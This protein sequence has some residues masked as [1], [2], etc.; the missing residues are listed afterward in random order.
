MNLPHAVIPVQVALEGVISWRVLRADGRVKSRGQMRNTITNA[1][2]DAIGGGT[3]VGSL[4]AYL[5][6]G[7]GVAAP[8]TG[9]TTLGSPHAT[10]VNRTST[11]DDT[12]TAA[13]VA[14]Y[15]G[16]WARVRKF[17]ETEATGIWTEVG[18]FSASSGGTM[19]N[20]QLFKDGGG[21]PVSVEVLAD[22]QL[23]VTLN[24]RLYSPAWDDA[25]DDVT[26]SFTLDE[27]IGAVVTPVTYNYTIRPQ[28]VNA[29]SWSP[30]HLGDWT[31]N[32]C[33]ARNSASFV[34]ITSSATGTAESSHSTTSY[35]GGTYY[36]DQEHV[37]EPAN[38]TTDIGMLVFYNLT[39]SASNAQVFQCALSPVIPKTSAKRLRV[40]VRY[41]FARYP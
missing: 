26:G 21:S 27:I 24:V 20:R 31:N 7:T 29:T 22:E 33:A 38:V 30:E 19:F 32:R 41:S 40:T 10:R 16:Q 35:V 4:T 1:A 37:W 14:P 28:R 13:S 5:A 6:V 34:A 36:V 23:E 12:A 8:T 3:T 17:I 11:G 39:G 18:F 9:D 2:L 15:Y 25:S